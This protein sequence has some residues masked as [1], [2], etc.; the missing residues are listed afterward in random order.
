MFKVSLNSYFSLQKAFQKKKAVSL[1]Y[2]FI[3]AFMCLAQKECSYLCCFF[4]IAL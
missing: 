1:S 4:Y 2:N 3:S